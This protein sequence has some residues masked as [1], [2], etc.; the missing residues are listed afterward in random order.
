MESTQQAL[1]RSPFRLWRG[2][3][4][5]SSGGWGKQWIL[6]SNTSHGNAFPGPL[7]A[8]RQE[9]LLFLTLLLNDSEGWTASASQCLFTCAKRAVPVSAQERLFP[10]AVCPWASSPSAAPGTTLLTLPLSWQLCGQTARQHPEVCQPPGTNGNPYWAQDFLAF[11][12]RSVFCGTLKGVTWKKN[13][14][15]K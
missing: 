3:M 10:F 7:T 12:E 15:I 4:L 9:G 11:P 1:W 13:S 14:V 6:N 5:S 2:G 8:R